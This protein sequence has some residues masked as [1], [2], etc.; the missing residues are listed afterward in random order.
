MQTPQ[1]EFSLQP[2]RDRSTRW[3]VF[4]LIAL[5]VVVY[6]VRIDDL[7]I[8]GEESRRATVAMEMLAT[9][10]WIV[11]RQQGD[12]FFMSARPPL[13]SWVMAVI[14]LMRDQ[15]DVVAVRLPSVMAVLL[16]VLVIYG[17]A[18]T[19]LSGTGAFAAGA[20]YATMGQVMQLGRLGETDAL[21]T[22]F[23]S[24]SLLLW[25]W[26]L[27]K[28]WHPAA[29][30]SVAWLCMALATLTKGPQGPTYFVASVGI[31]LLTTRQWR[32]AFSRSHL[33]GIAAAVGVVGMWL[34]PF[35][36]SM[37]V[38]GVRH[39]LTG[40]VSLYLN[41]WSVAHVSKHYGKFPLE[42]LGC[43]LPWSVFLGWFVQ[44][45]V[46]QGITQHRD[47]LLFLAV[48][49]AVSFPTIWLIP[50]TRSRF[51]M[52]MYPIFAVI[53]GFVVDRCTQD[54]MCRRYWRQTLIGVALVIVGFGAVV[55]G[56]SIFF[57]PGTAVVAQ[58]IG[59]AA[60]V[61]ISMALLAWVAW[62]SR[63]GATQRH[64]IAGVLSIA[65][66]AGIVYAGLVVSHQV[67]RSVD[68]PGQM[69]ELK[70]N[71]PADVE[72]VS[73]GPILHLF[74]YHYGKPIPM[75]AMPASGERVGADVYFSTIG[76]PRFAYEEVARINCERS[77]S[78]PPAAPA[79]W[80]VVIVGRGVDSGPRNTQR[81]ALEA[82][83]RGP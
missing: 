74:A 70:R 22:F 55:L 76:E 44:R 72:L 5:V 81:V 42:V 20:A 69:A 82:G 30:W 62:W 29:T 25:H 21:F 14:G 16:T 51:L 32:F 27:S 35:F 61:V 48:C 47:N 23:V 15:V 3:H 43:L 50:G 56:A 11:P 26:G 39:I 83:L 8:R 46:R 66:F 53:I 24:S 4:L 78:D 58:P 34:A 2:A 80:A 13:Q 73:F 79:P 17:Y 37:G 64:A 33:V 31:Y 1:G 19:F 36:G 77:T 7:T 10:D 41:D 71:L 57:A 67:G 12:P 60:A 68:T 45:E 63:S 28:R 52:S 18:R 9:G 40:D 75:L 49:L 65:S 6:F 59:I 54:A 38:E